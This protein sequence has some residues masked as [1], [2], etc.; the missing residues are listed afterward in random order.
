MEMREN[1]YVH[2]AEFVYYLTIKSTA[3]FCARMCNFIECMNNSAQLAAKKG[4]K[5]KEYE[6]FVHTIVIMNGKREE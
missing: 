5:K 6:F 3:S 1:G 4:R 2:A